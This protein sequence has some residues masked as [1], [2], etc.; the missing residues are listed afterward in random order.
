[1]EPVY[2]TVVDLSKTAASQSEQVFD[3]VTH[4]TYSAE[5]ELDRTLQPVRQSF[6]RRYPLMFVGTT[7]AGATATFLGI[8]QIL[9]QS[10]LLQSYPWLILALGVTILVVTGTLYKRLQ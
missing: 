9:L 4:V 5:R 1:M 10:R 2:K 8:E 3:S 7:A 6:S